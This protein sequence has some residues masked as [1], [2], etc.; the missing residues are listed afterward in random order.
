MSKFSLL[1]VLILGTLTLSSAF[2]KPIPPT[3]S[4]QKTQIRNDDTFKYFNQ[5]LRM[6]TEETVEEVKGPVPGKSILK[7]RII[8]SGAS[9]PKTVMS[10]FDFE[11][12]ME[13]SDEWIFP[14]TGIRKRRL[15]SPGEN[16]AD[17]DI[18]AAKTAM[19]RAGVSAEDIGMVIV[20]SSTPDDMFGD[21][22]TV[23][24]TL[25]I[26][27]AVAF[28][29][30]AA[31]S[32]FLFGVITAAQFINTG[33]YKNA[34]VI[35]A[36]A[37]SRWTDWEDRNTCILFGDGAGAAVLT[38]SEGEDDAGI[39]GFALHSDGASKE[40]LTLRYSGE[41]LTLPSEA[42][43]VV[44]SA[45]Y[46]KLYM[47]GKEIYK[48][49]TTQVPVVIKEA[50]ENAGMTID[51]VD[52]LL[53]HQANIRIMDT[54]AKKLKLPLD[55]IIQNLDDFGNTS[56]AS[57]PLAL[58]QAVREGRV[59]KGDIIAMSGFGAGLSWGAAIIRW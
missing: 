2:L 37:L 46:D 21:A 24:H 40:H 32:G 58:E 26:K 31:C 34:L 1:C 57:I 28:D 56:A 6:S 25:G 5:N 29:L 27:N 48:F 51:Q 3:H 4:F 11:T 17:L 42:G 10:N 47:T 55:K 38:A 50:L 23:A 59:K 7:A 39:L 20:C 33:T 30:T 53:L 49:A 45:K 15:L 54:V 41:A 8:G 12:F 35:G 52:H 19:E 44:T 9:A 36:D 18:E 16:L 43:Q 13:T 14:R 22:G